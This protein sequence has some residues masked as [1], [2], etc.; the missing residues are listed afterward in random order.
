LQKVIHFCDAQSGELLNPL[1]MPAVPSTLDFS[2][3]GKSV[4]IAETSSLPK[5]Q[6]RRSQSLRSMMD[7]Y[8]FSRARNASFKDPP[9]CRAV[10]AVDKCRAAEQ[11]YWCIGA[12]YWFVQ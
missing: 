1:K 4:V 8:G 11:G 7:R 12:G 5:R 10:R 2:P 3:D 6:E 9:P